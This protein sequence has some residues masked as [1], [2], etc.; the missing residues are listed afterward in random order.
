MNGILLPPKVKIADRQ[1]VWDIGARFVYACI[2]DLG[3][4][5]AAANDCAYMNFKFGLYHRLRYPPE[6]KSVPTQL[7]EA[8]ES[9]AAVSKLLVPNL[10]FLLVLERSPEYPFCET[11]MYRGMVETFLA[12]MPNAIVRMNAATIDWLQP[13]AKILMRPLWIHAPTEDVKFAPWAQFAFRSFPTR[14]ISGTNAEW[15]QDWAE[16]QKA[17]QPIPV[18]NDNNNQNDLLPEMTDHDRLMYIYDFV[19]RFEKL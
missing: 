4:A 8:K 15:V 1:K 9:L 14:D 3:T 16:Y 5:Q 17:I 2:D 11:N 7:V 12:A 6:E 18:V 19:K 10:P 13:S